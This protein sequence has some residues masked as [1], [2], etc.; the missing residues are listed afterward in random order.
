[1]LDLYHPGAYGSKNRGK[2]SCCKHTDPGADGCT[3]CK[4]DVESL[5]QGMIDVVSLEI[6][7]EGVF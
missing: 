7:V 3:P 4:M 2:W 5:K 6:D 1:M